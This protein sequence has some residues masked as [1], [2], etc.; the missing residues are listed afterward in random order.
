MSDVLRQIALVLAALPSAD[1]EAV[2]ARVGG[3]AAAR[4]G[5]LVGEV[6]DLGLAIDAANLGAIV[7]R[8]DA[9]LAA[10]RNARERVASASAGDIAVAL[11]GAPGALVAELLALQSWPWRDE[12]LARLIGSRKRDV[13]EGVRGV[14][15]PIAA[16]R[17]EVML[18]QLASRL[19]EATS[20]REQA[21]RKSWLSRLVERR[22]ARA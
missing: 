2:L 21:S 15:A 10:N 19:P 6:R 12:F 18:A 5:A 11:E 13:V 8:L 20:R 14:R 16:R 7:D 9:S 3:E 22:G 1:R 4:L 17:A